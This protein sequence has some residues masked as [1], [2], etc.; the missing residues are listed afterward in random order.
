MTIQKNSIVTAETL[1]QQGFEP[2][3]DDKNHAYSRY[4]AHV[5]QPVRKVGK[6][7][8]RGEI[9]RMVS[10]THVDVQWAG[11]K[12]PSLMAI[13]DLESILDEAPKQMSLSGGL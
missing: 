8:W 13:A 2:M 11:D 9:V 12:H 10:T 1:S 4:P 6:R 7:G 3:G 5:G